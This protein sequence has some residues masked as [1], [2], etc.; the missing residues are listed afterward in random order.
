M[1]KIFIVIKVPRQKKN[2]ET[3]Y[4]TREADIWWSTMK[5]RLVGL[6]LH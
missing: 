1:V 3:F 4:L 6:N 5:D 2:I